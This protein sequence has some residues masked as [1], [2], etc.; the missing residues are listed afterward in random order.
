MSLLQSTQFR[1]DPSVSPTRRALIRAWP[2]F[3]NP[4][5]WLVALILVIMPL[6]ANGFFLIEIF[7]TTLILGI[8]ALSLMFLA[9]YGGMVSL[10]QLTIAGFAGYMVAVFGMS[11]NANISLGWP[12]W[13][14]TPMALA[15]ATLFGT[16]GGALAVRTEGIYT[17]MITLAIGAAFY[18]F[19]NQNWAIF[20]GH[21]GINTVATPHFWGVDWRSDIAFYYVTLGVAAICYFAVQYVSRAPFGLALQGVRDNPRRMAALGFNPNAHRIAAYAFAAFIAALGGVLQVW[22]YRQIS[23]G[24]VSVGACIDVLIIAVVGGITR[25][26]GP[27][28]G[29]LIFVLLRTFALDVLIKL[30]LDGNR[31]RL[32]IGLGFLAIVFW[33]SDGVIGLWERWR[34]RSASSTQRSGGG[35]H[36]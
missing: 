31:F 5:A 12:W 9:G 15:L 20:N 21:T 24:S 11:G 1:P 19:T 28:I 36:G 6:I 13:L 26:I 17:I 29:A 34:R 4:A 30:G 14:A 10:M 33:S 32:L 35:R 7:A 16:L 18:Y 3:Q 22:N 27:F 25:P 23:P 8:I 2:E